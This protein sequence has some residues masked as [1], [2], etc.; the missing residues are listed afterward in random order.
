MVGL[1]TKLVLD[2]IHWAKV[3]YRA[4]LEVLM[5]PR[6]LRAPALAAAV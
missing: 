6:E 1:W 5:S 2:G 4:S 3:A